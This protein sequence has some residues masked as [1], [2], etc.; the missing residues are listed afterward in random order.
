VGGRIGDGH[1][2]DNK[3]KGQG[4]KPHRNNSRIPWPS[5]P[6]GPDESY[7]RGMTFVLKL[8]RESKATVV[9]E[10]IKHELVA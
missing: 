9:F 10:P 2:C 6:T 7:C 1:D 3:P 4:S 5:I 8:V